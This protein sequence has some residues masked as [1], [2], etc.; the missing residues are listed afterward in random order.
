MS[1]TS[2]YY[3]KTAPGDA[4]AARAKLESAVPQLGNDW[5]TKTNDWQ[6]PVAVN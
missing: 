5:A 1:A 2:K 4:T 6:L 3:I